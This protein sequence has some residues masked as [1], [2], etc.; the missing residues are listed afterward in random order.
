[1]LLMKL[2][3]A[4][5]GMYNT[6]T[7]SD[8]AVRI[9]WHLFIQPN[10]ATP[11]SNP[12]FTIH[13]LNIGTW[14]NATRKS[15]SAILSWKDVRYLQL[16]IFVLE[17]V[18]YLIPLTNAICHF[19]ETGIFWTP[20]RGINLYTPRGD[21]PRYSTSQYWGQRLHPIGNFQHNHPL[22]SRYKGGVCKIST[23]MNL[24]LVDNLWETV[25][26]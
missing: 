19:R 1:M 23:F 10:T 22:S 17:H 12:T 26:N 13:F 4:R 14:L 24:S 2:R 8:I 16:S 18:K 6:W 9:C 11:Q 7:S 21:N 3:N 15:S 25:L 20:R 5:H